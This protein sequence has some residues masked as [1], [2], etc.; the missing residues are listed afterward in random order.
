MPSASDDAITARAK[1][2]KAVVLS[3]KTTGPGFEFKFDFERFRIKSLSTIY[4]EPKFDRA[5]PFESTTSGT[6]EPASQ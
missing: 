4:L 2:R 6:E 1:E 5:R 3:H